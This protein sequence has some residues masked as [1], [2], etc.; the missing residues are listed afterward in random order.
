MNDIGQKD[1]ETYVRNLIFE[2]FKS[3]QGVEKGG[4]QGK[5]QKVRKCSKSKSGDPAAQQKHNK[6]S[7]NA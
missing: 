4:H 1:V 7:G 2:K 5:I 6:S 3:R